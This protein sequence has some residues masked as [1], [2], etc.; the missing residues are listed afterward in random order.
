MRNIDN[1]K[2]TTC[3]LAVSLIFGFTACTPKPMPPEEV[4]VVPDSSNEAGSETPHTSIQQ[5]ALMRN[6]VP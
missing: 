2:W 1:R 5:A 4:Q 3:L 6:P